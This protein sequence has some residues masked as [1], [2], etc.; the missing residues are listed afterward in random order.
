MSQC[1]GEYSDADLLDA[2]L[3]SDPKA[4]GH[5]CAS[6]GGADDGACGAGLRDGQLVGL[7]FVQYNDVWLDGCALLDARGGD[8][9]GQWRPG[10]PSR[11]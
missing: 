4:T 2:S 10:V 9:C 8:A 7:R 5:T 11:R 6:Y 3:P 1:R